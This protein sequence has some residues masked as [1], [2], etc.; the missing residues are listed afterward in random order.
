MV[1]GDAGDQE[2]G[3][4]GQQTHGDTPGKLR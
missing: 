4:E 3:E 1:G 2:K